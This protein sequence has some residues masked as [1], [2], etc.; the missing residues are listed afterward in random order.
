[1]AGARSVVM[2]LWKVPDQATAELMQDFYTRLVG[3]QPRGAA[4]RDAQRSLM[5]R[6]SERMY[7]GAFICQGD[8]G[9]LARD[10]AEGDRN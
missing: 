8:P 5:K 1:V 3:G 4:L 6:Y 7:W 9:P 10:E 2:S